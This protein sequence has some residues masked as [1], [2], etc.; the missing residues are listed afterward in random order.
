M[1]SSW[2][3]WSYVSIILATLSA[4][5]V[6][7]VLPAGLTAIRYSTGK[8]EEQFTVDAIRMAHDSPFIVRVVSARHLIESAPNQGSTRQAVQVSTGLLLEDFLRETKSRAVM[9]GGYLAS[10]ETLDEVGF[11]MAKGQQINRRHTSWLVDAMICSSPTR[12]AID[13]FD[14]LYPQ[15][16][17]FESCLQAGPMFVHEGKALR[18]DREALP[19][20]ERRFVSNKLHHA[21]ICAAESGAVIFGVTSP[22]PLSVLTLHLSNPENPS[23][24]KCTNAFR[25]PMG[26]LLFDGKLYGTD[27]VYKPTAITIQAK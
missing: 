5:S 27:T 3:L 25:L 10:L 16:Q 17:Q 8:L 19:E 23:H 14:K 7:A 6:G 1:C 18:Q 4:G 21:F 12:V 24:L 22:V 9:S 2:K 26:G 15:R 11:V 13:M 20:A